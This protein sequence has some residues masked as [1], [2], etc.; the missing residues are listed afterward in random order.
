M[1]LSHAGNPPPAR[2]LMVVP[3]LGARPEWLR[4]CLVS[5]VSQAAPIILTIRVVS[6]PSVAVRDL[7]HEIGVTHFEI[8][9]PGLSRALNHGLF[10]GIEGFDFCSWL[11]DDDL[12]SP[13]SL[14]RTVAALA[15]TNAVFVYGRTR[16][17]DDQDETLWVAY[18]SKLAHRTLRFTQDFVPQ[19]G[20]LIRAPVLAKVGPLRENLAN[21]MD[22]DLFLRL[23]AH[24]GAIYVPRE[25][26]AYRLHSNSITMTKGEGDEGDL[27][28]RQHSR[29]NSGVLLAVILGLGRLGSKVIIAVQRRLPCRSPALVDGRP[30][31]LGLTR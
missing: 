27:V 2:V 30:Y 17:F 18:P 12:L 13:G 9:E 4:R 23:L 21:A 25:L 10:Q 26:S 16:Y 8:R 24:G 19:P 14:A 11:G 1:E 28:R 7:C 31:T 20:S 22:L 6:P 5:I 29:T 3:T 15:S